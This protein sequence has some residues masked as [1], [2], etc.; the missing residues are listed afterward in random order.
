MPTDPLHLMSLKFNL[1][2]SFKNKENE[3]EEVLSIIG[4]SNFPYY[5]STKT[6]STSD[7]AFTPIENQEYRTNLYKQKVDLYDEKINKI[8]ERLSNI[9]PPI[10]ENNL[11][12]I[13]F[14]YD[15]V[16]NKIKKYNEKIELYNKKID[17]I[18]TKLNY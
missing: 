6:I 16:E 1:K 7:N 4:F 13:Q 12:G 15:N 18:N 2:E 3:S 17:W 5:K 9:S 8:N 11:V 14:Y 10:E